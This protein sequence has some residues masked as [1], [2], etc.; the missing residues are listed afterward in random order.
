MLFL[1]YSLGAIV[2]DL[3]PIVYVARERGCVCVLVNYWDEGIINFM[4]IF[5]LCVGDNNEVQL[6]YLTTY[7]MRGARPPSR[8]NSC[9][10]VKILVIASTSPFMRTEKICKR[11]F[12][13]YFPH[14]N[15]KH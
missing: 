2:S 6:P 5:E 7:Q 11:K 13:K 1:L 15:R 12:R 4:N 8:D 3:L 10:E 14:R 9:I